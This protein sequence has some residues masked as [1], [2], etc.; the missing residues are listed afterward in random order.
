MQ[1]K[2]LR[3]KSYRSFRIDNTTPP[4]AQEWLR[5]IETYQALRVNRL[6]TLTPAVR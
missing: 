5:H 4:D 6:R 2:S 1:I 3:T